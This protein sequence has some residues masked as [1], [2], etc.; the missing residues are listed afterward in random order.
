MIILL[1]LKAK[2]SIFA[3][4]LIFVDENYL[5]R[6]SNNLKIFYIITIEIMH[7]KKFEA[8]KVIKFFIYFGWYYIKSIRLRYV[9]DTLRAKTG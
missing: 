5:N 3:W 2:L 9:I 7:T 1:F 6:Q 8:F 4:V